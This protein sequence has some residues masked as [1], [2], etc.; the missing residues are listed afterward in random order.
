[1]KAGYLMPMLALVIS[2]SLWMFIGCGGDDDDDDASGG[3]SCEQGCAV[4]YDDCYLYLE[5]END[6]PMTRAEC[7]DYCEAEG[8]MDACTAACFQQYE[9]DGYCT[10]YI[11]CV[12]DCIL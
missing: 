12:Y 5:D 7:I 9:A 6:E 11:T 10:Q 4:I 2:I 3:V 8:G 1:M